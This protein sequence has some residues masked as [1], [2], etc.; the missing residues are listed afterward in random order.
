MKR[1]LLL[2]LALTLPFVA[3]YGQTNSGRIQA[4]RLSNKQTIV[5]TGATPDVSQGNVF[6]TNNGG[7]VTITN[8]LNG[9]DSQEIA[10]ICGD[11]NTTIQNGTSIVTATGSNITCTANLTNAFIYDASQSKWIQKSGGSSGGSGGASPAGNVGDLNS[12]LDGT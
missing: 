9:V 7:A 8:F 12:K 5:I 4:D 2:V 3:T 11:T 1:I 10:V 6:K